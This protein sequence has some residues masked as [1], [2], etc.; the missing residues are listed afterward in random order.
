MLLSLRAGAGA[1]GSAVPALVV[2]PAWL[3]GL[4]AGCVPRAAWSRSGISPG[5]HKAVKSI[6][7]TWQSH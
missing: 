1:S 5:P 3:R 2:L 4:Q 6:A 7:R